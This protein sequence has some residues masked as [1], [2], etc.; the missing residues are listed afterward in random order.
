MPRWKK[1]S[2]ASIALDIGFYSNEQIP[3]SCLA[4]K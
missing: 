4:G 2:G 1:R 3:L